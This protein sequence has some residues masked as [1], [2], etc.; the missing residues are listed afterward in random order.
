MNEA[1]TI[2]NFSERELQMLLPSVFSDPSRVYIDVGGHPVQVVSLG[3]WNV[4]EGPDFLQGALVTES[5]IEIGDIEF[6]RRESEW[7]AHSHS[8]DSR[9]DNVILHLVIEPSKKSSLRTVVISSDE[10]NAA[11]KFVQETDESD[12]RTLEDLQT[13]SLQR[14][15]RRSKHIADILKN[16]TREQAIETVFEEFLLRHSGRRH[17]PVYQTEDLL[18]LRDACTKSS[19]ARFLME[20]ESIAPNALQEQVTALAHSQILNEKPGLRAELVVNC[21]L[22]FALNC[23]IDNQRFPLLT[24]YWSAKSRQKYGLLSR[25]F[26]RL[27]QEYVW[28]QQGMLEYIRDH[29][30][31]NQKVREQ[32]SAYGFAEL[33]DF[34]HVNSSAIDFLPTEDVEEMDFDE[35]AIEE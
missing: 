11:Q 26:P 21:V 2:E 3:K 7:I 22:P 15:L 20:L 16:L 27:T 33:L 28:T 4:H 19:H 9:Y 24:W 8:Q 25:T 34:L 5:G 17:R 12:R 18:R 13:F 32:R 1:S 23:A 6:H 31:V 29:S 35:G 30:G 10:L 14:L